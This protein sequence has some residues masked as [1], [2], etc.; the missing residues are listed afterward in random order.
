MNGEVRTHE[1]NRL[2]FYFLFLPFWRFS[3][4][5]Q[6]S[7]AGFNKL[8]F[9]KP[10]HCQTPDDKECF[11]LMLFI[12]LSCKSPSSPAASWSHGFQCSSSA[13]RWQKIQ[14][15]IFH[16]G[17]SSLISVPFKL[18]KVLKEADLVCFVL[19]SWAVLTSHI[20][21]TTVVMGSCQLNVIKWQ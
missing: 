14:S 10:D 8:S 1:E 17:R 15:V 9:W 19:Q 12:C 13:S 3:D 18:K 6:V 7:S 11:F 16:F 20:F 4:G 21:A 2:F 5:E